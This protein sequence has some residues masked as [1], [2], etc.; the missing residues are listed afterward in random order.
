MQVEQRLA[1]LIFEAE[2][3]LSIDLSQSCH[4][5]GSIG[6]RRRDSHGPATSDQ[7]ERTYSS[8]VARPAAGLS[9][10]PPRCPWRRRGA[11]KEP[12]GC[13]T[14]VGR[15]GEGFFFAPR[16]RPHRDSRAAYC[17][18]AFDE[19]AIKTQE[20][21]HFS[22]ISPKDTRQKA[23]LMSHRQLACLQRFYGARGCFLVE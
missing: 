14:W 18:Q 15:R 21:A 3:L 22:E 1:R 8:R 10:D 4:G 17:Q 19:N 5:E 7:E 20:N 9:H 23:A 13:R 16:K 11:A 2:A 6:V 12:P